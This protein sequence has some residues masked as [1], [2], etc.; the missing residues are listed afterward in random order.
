MPSRFVQAKKIACR[1]GRD[2]NGI[3]ADKKNPR[4]P[5]VEAAG[6]GFPGLP[7][8]EAVIQGESDGPGSLIQCDRSLPG[9]FPT[10]LVYFQSN[11]YLSATPSMR[12]VP[13][14]TRADVHHQRHRQRGG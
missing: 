11:P 6:E 9:K 8:S 4:S 10:V 7:G 2:L 5:G 14:V 3:G 1:T 12:L 13:V